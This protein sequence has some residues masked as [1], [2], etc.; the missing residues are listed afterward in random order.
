[1]NPYARG[2][3]QYEQ[4]Y[5]S[6]NQANDLQKMKTSK[7][8]VEECFK[9]YFSTTRRMKAER[10]SMGYGSLHQSKRKNKS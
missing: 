9:T 2:A 6:D 10:S 4:A 3:L 5:E 8:L 7:C 1:M